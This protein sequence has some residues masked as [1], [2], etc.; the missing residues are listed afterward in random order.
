MLE[1]LLGR[2]LKAPG[3]ILALACFLLAG[4]LF[5]FKELN[6]EAYP[7]P[8]PPMI[9]VIAQP[10]GFSGEEVER[11]VTLPLEVG[12]SGMPHTVHI[13]SQSLFGLS[14]VK[15]YFDWN[16]S[17]EQARQ[18]VLNRL[19][20]IALPA[21]VQ[22]SISPWNAVGEVF[23]YTL[24]GYG[25][26][27]S[28]LKAAEDF[29]LERQWR[30][31]PGVTDVTSFG[32]E[33][34]QYQIEIDPNRLRAHKL[35]I[36]QINAAVAN[37]NQN[38]GGQRLSMGDESY[39]IRGVGLI[40]DEHDIEDIVVVSTGGTPVRIGD[41]AHVSMGA[42]PRLGV[43]G[44]NEKR[45]V[46][47]GIVLMR[48]GAETE[49]TLQGVYDRLAFIREKKLLPPGMEIKPY[50]ARG[51]LVHETTRTVLHNL[52]I[53]IL[54]VTGVLVLFLSDWRAAVVAAINIP[55]AL[56]IAFAGLVLTR[57]SANLISLGAV[58]FGIVVDSTVIMMEN[59]FR[60]VGKGG[61]GTMRDRILVAAREVAVPMTWSTLIICVAFL[62]LFTLTGVSGVIFDHRPAFLGVGGDGLRLDLRNRG[63]G[64]ALDGDLLPAAAFRAGTPGRAGRARGLREAVPSG[65]DDH[66]G[67]DA[68]PAPRGARAWHRRRHAATAR[69][70]GHRRVS[71]A[72]VP[73]AAAAAAPA[74]ARV[75]LAGGAAAPEG[76]RFR[77]PCRGAGTRYL[78]FKLASTCRSLRK[79]PARFRLAKRAPP[80]SATR[81]LIETYLIV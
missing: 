6:I 7:N 37:A 81:A 12:L 70:R 1:A 32:G 23:R 71:A 49:P 42:A 20:G 17:Y 9:E 58:D 43:I 35:T 24:E 65:A 2:V 25:Y 19:G 21:G 13:R 4:G 18:E 51:E 10:S 73:D 78:T 29:V 45:D 59:I 50:Y 67:R 27:L 15:C 47:Q 39:D 40:K 33:T 75:S 63:A 53:G 31:V 57:T 55:I 8:V 48:Y 28:Q 61:K 41:L 66:A 22:P 11:T 76:R 56:L 69:H 52:V 44:Q 80:S 62:P 26:S 79:G 14:D 68:G 77:P 64:R 34:R 5:A 60:H 74:S 54:L 46:V 30:R 3:T 36:A 38:V 16:I 72:R